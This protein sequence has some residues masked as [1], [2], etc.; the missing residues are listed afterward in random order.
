[1]STIDALLAVRQAVA[2][3]E[4]AR[5]EADQHLRDAVAA[6]HSAGAAQT[7]IAEAAGVDRAT[8]RRWLAV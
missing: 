7:L 2:D 1:M 6:A 3:R 8:V 5:A 4:R